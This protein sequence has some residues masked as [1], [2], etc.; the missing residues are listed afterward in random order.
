MYIVNN[1]SPLSILVYFASI[2][3]DN[4]NSIGGNHLNFE[5]HDKQL[6]TCS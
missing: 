4:I 5:V 6:N 2:N 3:I 1:K